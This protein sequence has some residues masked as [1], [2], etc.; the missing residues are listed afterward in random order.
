[1]TVD[2]DLFYKNRAIEQSKIFYQEK[3]VA[4]WFDIAIFISA[5]G[6]TIYGL[7]SGPS[8]FSRAGSILTLVSLIMEYHQNSMKEQYREKQFEFVGGLGQPLI[9]T[10]KLPQFPTVVTFAA[11]IGVI[12][13][14]LIWGYGDTWM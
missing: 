14:T 10:L 4:L 7:N 9:G 1:M 13:G 11:H 3:S 5:L 2:S 8:S 6:W 12:F